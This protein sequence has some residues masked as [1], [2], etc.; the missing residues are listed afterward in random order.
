MKHTSKFYLLLLIIPLVAL[1]A[2]GCTTDPLQMGPNGDARLRFLEIKGVD[3]IPPFSPTVQ[4]YRAV[5][6]DPASAEILITPFI[7]FTTYRVNDAMLLMNTNVYGL[8]TFTPYSMTGL[9]NIRIVTKAEDGLSRV[10]TIELLDPAASDAGLTTISCG[11]GIL[12]PFFKEGRVP[13]YISFA[14][15]KITNQY[16]LEITNTTYTLG[17]GKSVG[18][19]TLTVNGTEYAA[20]ITAASIPLVHPGSGTNVIRITNIS[21]NGFFTNVKTV[22]VLYVDP[23][24]DAR[25]TDVKFYTP[26]GQEITYIPGFDPLKP[27]YNLALDNVETV[28]MV[29]TTAQP[30]A[31]VSVIRDSVDTAGYYTIRNTYTGTQ[32]NSIPCEMGDRLKVRV[33]QGAQEKSYQWDVSMYTS[34]NGYGFRGGIGDFLRFIHQRKEYGQQEHMEVTGIVSYNVSEDDGFFIEDGEFGIY[35]WAGWYS[36]PADLKVGQRVRVQF[37]Y[38]KLW[39]GLAEIAYSGAWNSPSDQIITTIVDKKPRPIYYQSTLQ[40]Y[41][42][43]DINLEVYRHAA[44]MVRYRTTEPILT[45]FDSSWTGQFNQQYGFKLAEDYGNADYTRK[46]SA[47]VK[48]MKEGRE[49]VFFGPLYYD[50]TMYLYIAHPE[51]M[52]LPWEGRDPE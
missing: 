8:S 33:V 35:V 13:E 29:V 9:S 30:G 2:G 50:G 47:A 26:S 39:M 17:I 11:A 36:K 15:L 31:S 52:I 6:P 4:S 16:T 1:F 28:R 5:V 48:Y 34:E 18:G 27:S 21:P 19:S 45:G 43:A 12:S 37:R 14:D 10:Y 25:A 7:Y 38:A 23:A 3:L 41:S 20:G 44:R 51:Q 40:W 22:N 32:L 46:Y 49:G 42:M 24:N